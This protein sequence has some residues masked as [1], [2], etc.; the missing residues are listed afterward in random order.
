MVC[1]SDIT[2]PVFV[3]VNVAFVKLIPAM[4]TPLK[5]PLDKFTFGPTI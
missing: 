5:S 4:L 1:A 2:F 3:F